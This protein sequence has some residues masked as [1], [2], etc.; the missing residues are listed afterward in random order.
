MKNAKDILAVL[1]ASGSKMTRV[2][3]AAVEVFANT[4]APMTAQELGTALSK[5][6]VDVNKTTLYREIAFLAGKGFVE[7]IAFGDRVA[8]Y[9]LKD[10]GHHHHVV[11]VRCERVVDVDLDRDLDSQEKAIAKK[12]KF[13][14]LRH[15]LE[16]F[17]LCSSCK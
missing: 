9:E 4:A 8:R 10:A 15:S 17:G 6:G 14:I 12:T 16:F 2:R 5:R 1:K 11:C 3:V 13:T 7:E